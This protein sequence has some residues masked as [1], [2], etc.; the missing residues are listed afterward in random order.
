[1]A[2]EKTIGPTS[3]IKFLGI[4]IDTS[5][6]EFRLLLEKI[7]RRRKALQKM[8]SSK[9]VT[10]REIQSLLGLLAFVS[11]VMPMGR[12]FCKWMATQ[13]A[14]VKN[15][16]FHVRVTKDERGFLSMV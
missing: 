14:G 9:K 12:I 16:L 2:Q 4:V 10:V 15:L 3:C 1:M 6:G 13:I 11:R 8:L 5:L 7:L